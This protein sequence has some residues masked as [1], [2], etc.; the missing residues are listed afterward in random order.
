MMAAKTTPA[1]AIFAA[2]A[3][4]AGT[5]STALLAAAT[6]GRVTG[7]EIAVVILGAVGVGAGTAAGT[8]VVKNKDVPVWADDPAAG[9]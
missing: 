3:A 8:Y 4:A 5:A 1:K 2:V 6:D 9:S 7:V